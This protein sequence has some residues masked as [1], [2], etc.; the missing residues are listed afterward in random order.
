MFCFEIITQQ[1]SMVVNY[2]CT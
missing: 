2:P 1:H